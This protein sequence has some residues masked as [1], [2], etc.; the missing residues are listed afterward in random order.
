M[1]TFQFALTTNGFLP[2]DAVLPTPCY[3]LEQAKRVAKMVLDER[4]QVISVTIQEVETVAV[5]DRR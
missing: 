3:D 1:K 4:P 2:H 5:M